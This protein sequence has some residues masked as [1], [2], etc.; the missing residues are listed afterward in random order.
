MRRLLKWIS[1]TAGTVALIVAA[2]AAP[3]ELSPDFRYRAVY[4]LMEHFD[5]NPAIALATLGRQTR[6]LKSVT[7]I[8][9]DGR[10]FNWSSKPHAVIWFNEWANWCVPCR[11]EFPAMQALQSR[12]GRDK[13]RIVLLSQPRYWDADKRAAKALGLGFELV[14]PTQASASDLAAINLSRKPDGFVLP[15]TTF[16]Q[17][18]GTGIEALQSVKDWDSVVWETTILHWYEAGLGRPSQGALTR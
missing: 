15:E 1:V 5:L 14:T 2:F 18:S 8:N 17:T 3:W 10:S 6:A 9:A 12:V 7:L 16:L 4:V 13:L 11:M